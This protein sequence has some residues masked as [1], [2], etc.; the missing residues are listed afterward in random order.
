[1]KSI[2]LSAYRF[3]IAWPRILP[4]GRGT[5]NQKGL[6]FYSRLVDSLLEADIVPFVTLFHWDL[7]QALQNEGG[8]AARSTAEAFVAFADVVSRCLGDRVS[9]WITHNEPSVFAYIGHKFGSHA[10]GLR[11]AYT[12]LRVAHHLLLS[13]GWSV[14]VIRANC[15]AAN[16]GIA[17]NVNYNQPASASR[18]DY[19]VWQYEYGMWTRWFLDPLYG[20]DYPP[21][22]VRREIEKGELPGSGLDFVEEGD[23]AAIA[24][25]TDFLGINYYTRQ[26]SRDNSVPE[27]EN[28]PVTAALS[29]DDAENWQEMEGWEVYP[30][31]LFNVLSWLYFEYQPQAIYITENGASWSD[32]PDNQGRVKDTRRIRFLERHLLS[33]RRAI[34]SGIPLRGYFAWSLL[35]NF[36]WGYGFKQ[37]FGLVWVDFETQK[38]ILKDSALWYR[39]LIHK[40][41]EAGS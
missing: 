8:F 3:S 25:P 40:D 29:S 18:C 32:A 6:D 19:A 7:P 9:N 33:A 14:P 2:G 10:P 22:L 38:R 23:L 21:D 17:M 16:V 34:Q 12:A 24:V 11:D 13:H 15:A 26:L 31:G 28:L 20:R 4:Y 27:E 5:V 39:D 41:L 37:R 30:E 35:D 1:M 36:E